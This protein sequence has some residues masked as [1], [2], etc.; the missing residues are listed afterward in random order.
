MVL[1]NKI[2]EKKLLD[3]RNKIFL[4]KGIPALFKCGFERSPFSTA[5]F[6]R[7]NLGDYTYEL[8]RASKGSHLEIIVTHI[9][10]GDNWIKI[11]L[12]I[13]ELHPE[14]L[15]LRHLNGVD[16][17]KYHLPPNS[18]TKM[19]L[20]VDGFKGISLFNFEKH[21]L[22]FF[23]SESGLKRR[24]GELSSLIE[25]DLTNIDFFVERWCEL[26]QPNVTDWEGNRLNSH[27]RR[28]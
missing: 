20:R 28:I 26:H 21:K 8:C 5:W 23:N 25:T 13:F 3:V 14:L 17:L 2:S 11:F 7:N 19:R 4:E 6:G 16:G 12:N 1:F 22:K 18:L 9:S 24:I 27:P 15:S 10:K